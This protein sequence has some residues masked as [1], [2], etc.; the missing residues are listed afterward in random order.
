MT[1]PHGMPGPSSCV[2]CMD[3]E[4]LGAVTV[5]PERPVQPSWL[6]RFPGDC[7]LCALPIYIGSRITLTNRGR[8]VHEGCI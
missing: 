4:G 8:Y 1:C 5:E 7:Q 3:G 2:D 6:A